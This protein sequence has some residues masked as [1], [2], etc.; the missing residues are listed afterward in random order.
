[1]QPLICEN[2]ARTVIIKIQEHLQENGIIKGICLVDSTEKN[3]VLLLDDEPIDP[4]MAEV[5]WA[6]YKFALE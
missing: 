5:W 6:G 1:M 4:K 2:D 3:I